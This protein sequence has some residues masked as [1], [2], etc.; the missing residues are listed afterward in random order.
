MDSE[1]ARLASGGDRAAFAA[2]AERHYDRIYALAWRLT[3]LTAQA[4]DISQDAMVKLAGAMASF[5]GDC[6]FSTWA[7]RITYTTAIDHLRAAKRVVP[8]APDVMLALADALPFEA[9]RETGEELWSAV[10]LLPEQQRDAV[11]LVYGEDMSH[12]EAAAL[13]NCSEKT[14]SWHLHEARKRLRLALEGA[15]P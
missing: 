12:R 9:Q 8:L 1:L 5:R 13:M 11:L 3:G 10:R 4:E 7:Y 14:V 2:L 6:A 15:E